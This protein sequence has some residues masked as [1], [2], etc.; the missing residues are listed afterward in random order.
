M[1]ILWKIFCNQKSSKRAHKKQHPETLEENWK[2]ETNDDK[3]INKQHQETLEESWQIEI[4]DY[5]QHEEPTLACFLC[6]KAKLS[7][8]DLKK[9]T[10]SEHKVAANSNFLAMASK[11]FTFESSN[12][13]VVTLIMEEIVK[14]GKGNTDQSEKGKSQDKEK[15]RHD[16]IFAEKE[17]KTELL[18]EDEAK[19][20]ENIGVE[21]Q[22]GESQKVPRNE[23]KRRK[24]IVFG[25]RQDGGLQMRP[26]S[27]PIRNWLLEMPR[28]DTF[29]GRVDRGGGPPGRLDR[30]GGPPGP[31]GPPPGAMVEE[32]KD[33]IRMEDHNEW[34]KV[35]DTISQERWRHQYPKH[36]PANHHGR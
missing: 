7:E 11:L 18:Q 25:K 1:F 31:P 28:N 15:E 27:A 32:R 23:N 35:L 20:K 19:R 16:E 24:K 2:I 29:G 8:G 34:E 14:E 4:D 30:G 6:D 3:H 12:L 21:I 17:I 36:I 13:S 26:P 10:E 9:H 5:L 33:R 22:T